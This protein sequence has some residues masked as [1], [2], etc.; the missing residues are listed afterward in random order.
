LAGGR[1]GHNAP[2]LT[3]G[4]FDIPTFLLTKLVSKACFQ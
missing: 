3:G 4:H 2:A 1:H